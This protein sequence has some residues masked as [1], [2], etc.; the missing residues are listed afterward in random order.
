MHLDSQRSRNEGPSISPESSEI[1]RLQYK[2][3]CYYTFIKVL[4]HGAFC[5][6]Y[7]VVDLKSS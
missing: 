7:E 1:E 5:T 3:G 2:Y 4:G 6:V